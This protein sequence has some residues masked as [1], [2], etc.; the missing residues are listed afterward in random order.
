[1][2]FEAVGAVRTT[3]R[4][5]Q[6]LLRQGESHGRLFLV[7]AGSVEL[8]CVLE[9]GHECVLDLVLPGE[10]FGGSARPAPFSAIAREGCRLFSADAS[11][12]RRDQALMLEDRRA[13][14]L[15]ERLRDALVLD[16]EERVMAA[17][18][19]LADRRSTRIPDGRRVDASTPHQ[20]A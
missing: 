17:L 1:R 6:V 5:G 3:A 2:L 11:A 10:V 14:R 7:E 20:D 16:A 9:S 12:A 8:S 19:D 13:L 4:A 18:C 15:A